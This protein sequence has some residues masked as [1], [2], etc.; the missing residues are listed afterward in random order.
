[1]E[2]LFRITEEMAAL[3]VG[4]AVQMYL[5]ALVVVVVVDCAIKTMLL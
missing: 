2:L 3:M 1:L 5:V 4:V